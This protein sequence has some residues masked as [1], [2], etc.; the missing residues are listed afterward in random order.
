MPANLGVFNRD[1]KHA[2]VTLEAGHR[3]CV[4]RPLLHALAVGI[5]NRDDP[6]VV[7]GDGFEGRL[8]LGVVTCDV[9]VVGKVR[10]EI[11]RRRSERGGWHE[12]GTEREKAS[13]GKVSLLQ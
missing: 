7:A 13:G 9:G 12:H 5:I 2:I 6:Q 10:L 1:H 11:H 4:D 3:M 8:D